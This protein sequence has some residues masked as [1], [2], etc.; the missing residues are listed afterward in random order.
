V[1]FTPDQRLLASGT[2]DETV[3]VW[4]RQTGR[5]LRTLRSDRPYERMNMSGV[6]GITEAQKASLKILGAIEE[7]DERQPEQMTMP[8][9]Q[10]EELMTLVQAYRTLGITR[11]SVYNRLDKGKLTPVY[12]HGDLRL[13]RSEIEAWRAQREQQGRTSKHGE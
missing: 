11:Q 1:A 5:C 10:P 7:Q 2:E 3:L 9:Y 8:M 13:L 12:L 6:T 4:E